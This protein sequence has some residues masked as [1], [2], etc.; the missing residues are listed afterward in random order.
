VL[1]A[2][3]ARHGSD[4]LVRT[5]RTEVIG[6]IIRGTA[7]N[8]ALAVYVPHVDGHTPQHTQS[9]INRPDSIPMRQAPP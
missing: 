7:P 9:P 4:S 6:N 3:L 2:L 8:A 1:A 5:L